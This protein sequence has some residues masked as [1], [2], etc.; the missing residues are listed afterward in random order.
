MK[1]KALRFTSSGLAPDYKY[2]SQLI[3]VLAGYHYLVNTLGISEDKICVCG[4]SAGGNLA[5]A[6]LLH[7]A[8]PHPAVT[9][10][11]SLGPTPLQ[12]G[13]SFD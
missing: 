8:R 2:P 12:P 11:A 13:V 3:E 4:D 5:A 10:P 9:V 1:V 6:F 7:L